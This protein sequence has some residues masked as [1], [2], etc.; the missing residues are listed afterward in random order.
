MFSQARPSEGHIQHLLHSKRE[1]HAPEHLKREARLQDYEAE[2][3]RSIADPEKFWDEIA[4][5]LHW[6]EPWTKTFEWNYPTFRWF[7]G[8]RCNIV[9]NCL[10]RQVKAGRRN[11]VAY[12]F[13]N[14]DGTEQK[15]WIPW[16][17]ALPG[18]P[19]KGKANPAEASSNR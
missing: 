6:H 17:E 11:K 8:G 16:A 5:E 15:P 13:T 1:I 14:E 12:I 10:D 3:K 18:V 19:S 9:Y 7:L 2:Y 4:K